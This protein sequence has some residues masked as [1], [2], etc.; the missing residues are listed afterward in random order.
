MSPQILQCLHCLETSA[1]TTSMGI[2]AQNP[3]MVVQMNDA[4]LS[5]KLRKLPGVTHT[6]A[7]V[8]CCVASCKVAYALKRDQGSAEFAF[9]F[10]L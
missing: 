1:V 4:P 9:L 3:F 7:L 6:S 10:V 2:G 8:F 5:E